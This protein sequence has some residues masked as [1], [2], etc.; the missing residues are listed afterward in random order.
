MR[1]EAVARGL[2]VDAPGHAYGPWLAA[3]GA[4]LKA[5]AKT[6]LEAFLAEA[7]TWPQQRRRDFIVW[8]DGVRQG[9]DDPGAAAPHPLMTRLVLPTLKAWT[10]SEPQAAMP[11][12]LLGRFHVWTLDPTPPLEHFRRALERDAGQAAARRGVI[13]A[14]FDI[15][16]RNQHHLPD[17]YL[18][19]RARDAASMEEAAALAQGLPDADEAWDLARHAAVLRDRAL[20]RRD[21]GGLAVYGFRP[22]R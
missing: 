8:L 5:A 15:V 9:L 4:G 2:G 17:T 6:A 18:G 11:H 22:E 12:L 16:E 19:D 3:R 20:R 13:S 14:L 1:L 21:D 7:L 10:D